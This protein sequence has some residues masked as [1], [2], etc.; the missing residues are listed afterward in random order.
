MNATAESPA[1]TPETKEPII[2]PKP[3]LKKSKF[4]EKF[5][6][7]A[8]KN[9]PQSK[10]IISQNVEAPSNKEN[11]S[12]PESK[13]EEAPKSILDSFFK[14]T[15]EK[16][17]APSEVASKEEAS[18]SKE[19]NMANLRKSR[20]ELKSK[21]DELEKQYK[22]TQAKIPTDYEITRSERDKYKSDLELVTNEL[23]KYS[24]AS[25]PEFKEKYETPI[26]NSIATI[27]K[28]LLVADSSSEINSTQFMEAVS[29]PESK[30][31]TR[32]LAELVEGMDNF[33]KQKIA[34]A[35]S[36]FDLTREARD[37]ELSNPDHSFK[38]HQEK[39]Q[40]L[41]KQQ[42]EQYHSVIDQVINKSETIFPWFKEVG[43]EAWDS[44]IKEVK[45]IAKHAWTSP[46]VPTDTQAGIALLAVAADK[47]LIPTLLE[48]QKENTRLNSELKK[49]R[50]ST[51]PTDTN[52]PASKPEVKKGRGSFSA[53]LK[54]AMNPT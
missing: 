18:L 37:R 24:L 29:L 17:S 53:A 49:L 23:K 51:P 33:S 44:K 6:A 34:N 16:E 46:S 9:E 52:R 3:E 43:D 14:A 50:G 27:E 32:R 15:T 39:Q 38:L 12:I 42:L 13:P 2:A 40:T 54:A 4:Y 48:A 22:Q 45:A 11:I 1:A 36:T 35:I 5:K 7:G 31:R 30:E 25:T 10:E 41:Q 20:E 47:I 26:K 19:E 28:A 21:Y 8:I